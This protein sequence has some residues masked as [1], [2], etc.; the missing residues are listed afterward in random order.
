MTAWR[1]LVPRAARFGVLLLAGCIGSP[2][3]FGGTGGGTAAAGGGPMGR[4]GSFGGSGGS[5]GF[6][7]SG[8]A[9]G[10]GGA[11]GI[12]AGP[13]DASSPLVAAPSRSSTIAVALNHGLFAAV[14]PDV[15]AILVG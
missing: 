13:P 11:G 3:F 6:A 1:G 2:T 5:G 8:V 15:P 14:N 9:G 4:G 10:F 12:A 7:G